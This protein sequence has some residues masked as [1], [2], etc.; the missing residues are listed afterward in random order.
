MDQNNL[1]QGKSVSKDKDV[2]NFTGD[3]IGNLLQFNINES[4]VIQSNINES[5]S[6]IKD[7]MQLQR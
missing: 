1:M 2:K 5:A 6:D 4:N 7:W 3:S